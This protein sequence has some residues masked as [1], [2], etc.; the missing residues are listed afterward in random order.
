MKYSFIILLVLCLYLAGQ[1]EARCCSSCASCTGGACKENCTKSCATCK[2]TC[3]ETCRPPC[4]TCTTN[5]CKATCKE[6]CDTCETTECVEA[7]SHSCDICTASTCKKVCTE[8]TT[9]ECTEK[10][11]CNEKCVEDVDDTII[12]VPIYTETGGEESTNEQNHGTDFKAD[13]NITNTVNNENI[14]HNPVSVNASMVNNIEIKGGSGGSSGGGFAVIPFPFP[15]PMYFP[16][17]I[18][19]TH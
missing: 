16:R 9:S 18:N 4:A 8:S 13:L 12:P 6:T 15:F 7:C 19:L 5:E 14:I 2:A 11:D 3:Q 1:V 17:N 10:C